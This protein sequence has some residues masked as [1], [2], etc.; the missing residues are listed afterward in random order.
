M[1]IETKKIREGSMIGEKVWICDYRRPDL[2]KKPIRNIAPTLCVI[3]SNSDLPKNKTIYYSKTHFKPISTKGAV[4]NRVISPVDNTGF[5]LFHGVEL[6]VFDNEDECKKYFF[7]QCMEVAER[8]QNLIDNNP[9]K[10]QFEDL[11]E[12]CGKF[13]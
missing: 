4:L 5:R 1:K 13:R 10:Q 3:C 12:L 7:A 2:N 9:L 8:L 6:N 11:K